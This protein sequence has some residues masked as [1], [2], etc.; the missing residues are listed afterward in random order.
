MKTFQEILQE[1]LEAYKVKF[2]EIEEV[3]K[4]GKSE[5]LF[6]LTNLIENTEEL[7]KLLR[8]S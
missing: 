1:S 8:P 7:I 6:I 3:D 5:A 2:H 4:P